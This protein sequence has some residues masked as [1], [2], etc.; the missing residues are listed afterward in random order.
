MTEKSSNSEKSE[1]QIHV[2]EAVETL[3][4]EFKRCPDKYLTEEDLRAFLY[5]LL[6]EHF[7]EEHDSE[8]SSKSIPLHCEV[9]WYGRDASL[10]MRSD[11][12]IFDVSSLRTK[13]TGTFRLPSKGYAFNKPLVV[14]ELK[15]RRAGNSSNS[16]NRFMQ[17]IENDR[18]RITQLRGALKSDF[19]SHIL[20]FDKKNNMNPD[21]NNDDNHSENYIFNES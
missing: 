11:I 6:L 21:M 7:G 2:D 5:H 17:E 3:I 8:D 10:N 15:L 20:I 16:N 9:R 13:N 19:I 14:I 12:V 1:E 4:S 18:N